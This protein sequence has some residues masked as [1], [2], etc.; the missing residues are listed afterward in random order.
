MYGIRTGIIAGI[1]F[2][3]GGKLI[4]KRRKERKQEEIEKKS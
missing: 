2:V 3:I 1:V 4:G